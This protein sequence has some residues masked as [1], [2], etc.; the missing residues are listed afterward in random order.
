MMFFVLAVASMNAQYGFGTENPD[1]SAVLDASASDRGILIPRV[2]LT[3]TSS[4][5]PVS[6][7]ATSL[8]VYNTAT[9]GDVTPGFYYWD[10]SKWVRM[11]NQDDQNGLWIANGNDIYNGNS[12]NVG[13]GISA[14]TFKLDVN[15]NLHS[16]RYIMGAG[17][18]L[19][20][21]PVVHGQS[22]ITTW[23]AMQ[24]VGN[25]QANVNYTPVNVGNRDDASVIIPNQQAS[26]IGLIIQ[27]QASQTGNLTEWRNNS[28]TG[29]SA[30]D[31][32]GNL[33]LGTISPGKKLDVIGEARVN[34]S[35]GKIEM[36]DLTTFTNGSS[37]LRIDADNALSGFYDYEDSEWLFLTNNSNAY[38]PNRIYVG[39]DA[40]TI[41]PTSTTDPPLVVTNLTSTNDI[42][43]FYDNTTEV[44]TV[45][46]GGNVGIGTSSPSQKLHVVGSIRMVDGNEGTGKV[47]NSDANGVG[48]WKNL[49]STDSYN[50][51]STGT[52]GGVYM[53]NYI[54]AMGKVNSDGTAANIKNASSSRTNTGRYSITFTNS[55]PDA[56]YVIILTVIDENGA[57][58]DD[59]GIT[60]W[61]QTSSGFQV[62]IKDSDNGGTDG[63]Y[64][65]SEF[66]FVVLDF[67]N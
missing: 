39:L 12:G 26:K 55:M 36:G 25:R 61:N 7:P 34:T 8:L 52:D 67:N 22:V 9:A 40:N 24:L 57:N 38:V 43:H 45:L 56:N 47:L 2:A 30:V 27:G 3:S 23:W 15:G 31:A 4:A 17:P 29:L 49:V 59:P 44:F 11:I 33:G 21:I 64:I 32:S 5:S 50:G 42:V 54:K 62:R 14:P 20:L 63:V 10:G 19:S 66:M 48:S 1:Q 16:E 41:F 37:A 28:G 6:S 65:N 51:I 58:R 35:S 60:Y 18:D 13:I 53:E 46:D